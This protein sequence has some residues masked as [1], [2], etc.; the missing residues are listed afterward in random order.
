MVQWLACPSCRATDLSL[1]TT[2]TQQIPV[3]RGQMS[4]EERDLPGLDLDAGV[5]QEVIEGALHCSA[6]GAVYPVR[7]GIPRMLP[8]GSAPGPDSAH[9]LTEIDS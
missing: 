5:Q 1:E 2:R 7:D 4:A 3:L 6:C 9:R 8:S